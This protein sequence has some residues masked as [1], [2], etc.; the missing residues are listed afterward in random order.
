MRCLQPPVFL[1]QEMG[2]KLAGREVL[3]GQVPAKPLAQGLDQLKA[4]WAIAFARAQSP[5]ASHAP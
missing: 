1:A 5:E 4:F 2:T 3:F